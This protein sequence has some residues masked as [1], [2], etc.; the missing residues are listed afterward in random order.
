VPREFPRP[1]SK[2]DGLR[3]IGILDTLGHRLADFWIE[4]NGARGTRAERQATGLATAGSSTALH[5][6]TSGCR[7]GLER[8][9]LRAS[10]PLERAAAALADL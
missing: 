9:E 8:R 3:P 7:R 1:P 2:S 6:S 10:A 5:R 4:R